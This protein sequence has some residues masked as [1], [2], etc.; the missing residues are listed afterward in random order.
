MRTEEVGRFFVDGSKVGLNIWGFIGQRFILE[1][2]IVVHFRKQGIHQVPLLA[3][4]F[5]VKRPDHRRDHLLPR[6]LWLQSL[7]HPPSDPLLNSV[8][9]SGENVTALQDL[10]T[11][12]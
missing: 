6:G 1:N 5:P 11:L 3:E 8:L 12:E 7:S 9:L 2:L 4:R 10:A